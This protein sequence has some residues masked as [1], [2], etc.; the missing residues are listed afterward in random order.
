LKQLGY[1]PYTQQEDLEEIFRH[2]V[3]KGLLS[4]GKI[5]EGLPKNRGS[6]A[7]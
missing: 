7:S 4:E 6:I 2:K 1:L 5:T 3:F